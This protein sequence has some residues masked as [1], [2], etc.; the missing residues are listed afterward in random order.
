MLSVGTTVG[1]AEVAS[2]TTVD[3][4]QLRFSTKLIEEAAAEV[5]A[6][7]A[8]AE[9]AA[10]AGTTQEPTPLEV[11]LNEGPAVFCV[12]KPKVKTLIDS[13]RLFVCRCMTCQW[14]PRTA[15]SFRLP[16]P[17]VETD[18]EGNIWS[19]RHTKVLKKGKRLTL[20]G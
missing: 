16:E 1:V 14:F 3:L 4:T 20:I 8:A 15:L 5:T 12:W 19:D 2:G 10:A 18:K 7:T 9:A 11:Q 13:D 17:L 6:A